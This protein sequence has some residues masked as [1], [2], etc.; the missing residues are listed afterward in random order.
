MS[1][2]R[3]TPPFI[4]GLVAAL[5]VAAATDPTAAQIYPTRPVTIV[6]PFSPALAVPSE[7]GPSPKLCLTAIP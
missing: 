1:W 2:H 6:V 7:R 4:A 5:A 3:I